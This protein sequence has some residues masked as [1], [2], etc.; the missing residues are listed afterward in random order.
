MSIEIISLQFYFYSGKKLQVMLN[1][2]G[3]N[4]IQFNVQRGER[5][6]FLLGISVAVYEKE[7][8][9]DKPWDTKKL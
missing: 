2:K 6:H 3:L 7:R 5:E 9:K 1:K 4:F 8:K